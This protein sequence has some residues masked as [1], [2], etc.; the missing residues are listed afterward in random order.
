MDGLIKMP[1]A[2]ANQNLLTNENTRVNCQTHQRSVHLPE[3]ELDGWKRGVNEQPLLSLPVRLH[4]SG[5]DLFGL[6][7]EA[8]ARLGA[9]SQEPGGGGPALPAG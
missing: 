5:H 9:D 3:I 4:D 6:R 2:L 8:Q 7:T 1:G